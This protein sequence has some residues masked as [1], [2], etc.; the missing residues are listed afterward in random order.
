VAKILIVEDDLEFADVLSL[1]LETQGYLI[2]KANNGEDALQLLSSFK[3]DLLIFDWELPGVTGVN[4]CQTFR[5]QGGTTPILF[6]TGK[7]DIDSKVMGLETGADDYMC[8]PVDFRELGARL[9]TLLRRPSGL[10]SSVLTAAGITLDPDT[11]KVKVSGVEVSLS[12]REYSLLE[13]LMRH[14]N[15]SYSSKALLD[16]VWTSDSAMSEDTV[17]STMRGLRKKITLDGAECAIKTVAGFGYTISNEAEQRAER[18][19]TE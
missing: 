4:V 11:H 2:E 1:W 13:F 7:S 18:A 5:K 6:L 14:A 17:R 19:P 12:P 8:K 9:R 16:S 15:K 3:Y 10:H